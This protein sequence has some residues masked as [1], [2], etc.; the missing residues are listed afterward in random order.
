MAVSEPSAAV[1]L[2]TH[3]NVAHK[4]RLYL[5]VWNKRYGGWMF[6]GGLVEPGETPEQAAVRELFEETGVIAG[7]SRLVYDAPAM[8][9]PTLPGRGRHVYVCA[10]TP[11]TIVAPR[12][13]ETGCPPT[14]H[15][16]K[17]FLD[18]CPFAAFYRE[19]FDKHPALQ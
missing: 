19:M 16:L 10:V 17:E 2:V 12:E 1:A 6:P 15:S 18:W 3:P 11:A 13:M 8:E 9:H 14:W 4:G 5:V 7:E